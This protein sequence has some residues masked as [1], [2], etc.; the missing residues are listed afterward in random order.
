M[1]NKL[2]QKTRQK[3]RGFSEDVGTTTGNLF[4]SLS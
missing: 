1:K 3:G 4:N 2:R